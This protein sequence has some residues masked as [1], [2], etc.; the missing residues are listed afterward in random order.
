[1]LDLAPG[2]HKAIKSCNIILCDTIEERNRIV[3]L[4]HQAKHINTGD[5]NSIESQYNDKI[6][7]LQDDIMAMGNH[8][9]ELEDKKNEAT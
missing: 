8:L 1:M 7:R 6:G 3:P 5:I 4:L 2:I 9:A